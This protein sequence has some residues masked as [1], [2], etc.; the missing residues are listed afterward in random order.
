M[1]EQERLSVL[2]EYAAGHT[3]TRTTIDKLGLRDFADLMIELARHDLPL[4]KPEETPALKA[5]RERA[6]A[7][8]QPRLKHGA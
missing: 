2:Y 8:L 5:H 6:R 3:G 7:I 4:P 1:T